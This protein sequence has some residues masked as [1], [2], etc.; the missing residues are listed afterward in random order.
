MNNRF[1]NTISGAI[2]AGTLLI[3]GCDFDAAQDAFEQF[4]VIIALEEINTNVSVRFVDAQTDEF[5]NEQVSMRFL[6]NNGA[7]VI[8]IYSDPISELDVVGGIGGFGIKNALVPS[9][10]N[11]IEVRVVGQAQ[12]FETGSSTVTISNT[13]LTETTVFMVRQNQTVQ[14]GASANAVGQ[15]SG[16]TV[17]QAVQLSTAS[18]DATNQAAAAVSV[19]VGP[20]AT[21][22]AGQAASGALQTSIAFY[23]APTTQTSQAFPG[24]YSGGVQQ[25]SGVVTQAP[26]TTAGFMTVTVTD[27]SG[28][29]VTSFSPP[30]E[31]SIDVPGTTLNPSTGQVIK[32]GEAISIMSY[33]DDGGIWKDEGSAAVAGP[34]GN[35]NFRAT[36][37][38]NHLSTWSAGYAGTACPVVVNVARNGNIGALNMTAEALDAAGG[39]MWSGSRS[40]PSGSSS[41]T[42][43]DFPA[44][45]AS[46]SVSVDGTNTVVASPCNNTVN[47]SLPAPA[48]SV[49]DVTFA[50]DFG[51]T[52]TALRTTTI[53]SYTINYRKEGQSALQSGSVIVTN[54]NLTHD[55]LGRITGGS[56]T[57][58][59]LEQGATYIFSS[60]FD[61]QVETRNEVIT[62][63]SITLDVS[64][65]LDGDLCVE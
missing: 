23:T 20:V 58:P 29:E 59:G 37:M 63:P 10:S 9:E 36:F 39:I 25:S 28:N 64:D 5:L 14:G 51:P 34:D 15:A 45:A 30:I 43:D 8:D 1:I 41:D 27:G 46:I 33:D 4:D 38:T 22:S 53:S 49:I 12:G 13:G 6:G 18:G 55:D 26:I 61:G 40:M 35:G 56:V 48:A 3:A 42:I 57:I 7:D 52:C 16:G 32:N 24:G 62:G 54:D 2:L 17:Q 44:S 65:D 60:S 50:L 11:P 31:L 47:V 19:P 21:T